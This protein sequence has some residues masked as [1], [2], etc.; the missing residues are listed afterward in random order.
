LLLQREV[1]DGLEM[2]VGVTSDPSFGPLVACGLGGVQ[3]ELL[4]D[5]AFRL[6]PVTDLDAEEMISGLRS[7]PLFDGFRGAPRRDKPR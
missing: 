6:T 7:A 5:V 3:V 4:R 1:R 2:I